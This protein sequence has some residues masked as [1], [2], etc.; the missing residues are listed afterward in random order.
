M[1]YADT[2]LGIGTQATMLLHAISEREIPSGYGV[3]YTETAAWYN[4][5]ERG[6]S[7]TFHGFRRKP[8]VVCFAEC[9]NSDDIVIDSFE[10]E[11]YINPPTVANFTEE[12]Y[13][14]RR[15]VPY[16]AFEDAMGVVDALVREWH[17]KYESTESK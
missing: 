11:Y 6:V 17:L 14:L 7:V 9:R 13:L 5:R 10:V 1:K 12:T 8:L 3:A 4:G 15:S 2:R 16:M